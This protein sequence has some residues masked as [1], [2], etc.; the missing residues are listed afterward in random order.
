VTD[1]VAKRERYERAV[2]ALRAGL[3]EGRVDVR[4]RLAALVFR[5]ALARQSSTDGDPSGVGPADEHK[6]PPH[7]IGHGSYDDLV[8]RLRDTIDRLVPATARVLVVSRGDP[9]LVDLLGRQSGHFP[10]DKAGEWAGFYPADSDSAIAHLEELRADGADFLVFP[11]TSTWWLD[12]YEQLPRHLLTHAR[13]A[14]HDDDCVIFD[15]R[16]DR[17]RSRDQP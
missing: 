12:Y 13:T 7:S 4:V 3:A 11:A 8:G 15:L 2:A 6:P 5:E 9:S 10:Q 1:A 16:R 17:E 14:H